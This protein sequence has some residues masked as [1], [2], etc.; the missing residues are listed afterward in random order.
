M[1]LVA[2][3]GTSRKNVGGNLFDAVR[4]QFDKDTGGSSGTSAPPLIDAIRNDIELPASSG[5]GMAPSVTVGDN[6]A[7]GEVAQVNPV[8]VPRITTASYSSPSLSPSAAPAQLLGGG[9]D[10]PSTSPLMSQPDDGGGETTSIDE[11]VLDILKPKYESGLA[12][13]E[14]QNAAFQGRDP[15]TANVFGE[16]YSGDDQELIGNTAV[17]DAYIRDALDNGY[18]SEQDAYDIMHRDKPWLEM[19]SH[20]YSQPMFG[21]ELDMNTESIGDAT[22][23][24]DGSSYD[25]DHMTADKMT[26]AQYMRYA[27]MG[28]G[29]RPIEEIDPLG[30]YS[31]RR[32]Q[33]DHDFMPFMP[34]E[35]SYVNMVTSNVID[36]PSRLGA[37]IANLRTDNPFTPDYSI[38]YGTGDGR[39]TISGKDFDKLSTAYLNQFDWYDRFR[40]EKYLSE[41]DNSVAHVKEHVIPDSTGADTYHYGTLKSVDQNDDGTFNL[42]FS[43]GSNVDISREY[44][45]S[46]YDEST[47]SFAVPEPAR[48]P[49]SKAHGVLPE[50]LSSLNDM[51]QI[52]SMAEE[53]GG[54]P[55]DYADVIYVPDMVMPNGE[56][57][58]LEDVNRI[59]ADK[60]PENDE[61]DS[62]DDDLEY[63]FDR[64][65]I[66]FLTD[67]KP[68]RLTSQEPFGVNE[69]TGRIEADLSDMGNN[70]W[71]WTFGSIPISAPGRI[72]WT[73]SLFNA[74]S[75]LSGADPS[76]YDT[77][78]DSYGL[79]AGNY[80]DEGKPRYGVYDEKGNRNDE[81]SDSNLFWNTAG[82]AA[83]PLTEMLV[84]PIGEELIP[85][86]KFFRK[87]TPYPTFG[88]LLKNT[89]IGAAEEGIEED[90]GNV[91]EDLT[92]YGLPGL[93]A[94]EVKDEQGNVVYDDTNRALRDY[95]TPIG[96]RFANALDVPSLLN[97]FIG[98]AAVTPAMDLLYSPLSN[99][100]FFRQ[101]GPSINRSRAIRNTG[102]TP[103]VET[104]QEREMRE[105]MERGERPDEIREKLSDQYLQMFSTET[106]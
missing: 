13:W 96:D 105:A 22:A 70:M 95:D 26:G 53:Y 62:S 74:A 37:A 69:T 104:D 63:G 90:L 36:T 14:I 40:P 72:P 73:Y 3:S 75:G 52:M 23:M 99:Q 101:L 82:N 91:F 24:D 49:V 21:A 66:P 84:G 64:G 32:E 20:K 48:V 68:R 51:D 86:G 92:Q 103:Y 89:I 67:N 100:T 81:L 98:G 8:S 47:N 15:R 4:N 46:I 41:F 106:D 87:D 57:V 71:D 19:L 35:T 45:D 94:N 7:G 58:S 83:V 50:D 10:V 27:N 76:R 25:Y 77:A 38:S 93:F 9:G 102:I 6:A 28:M 16:E 18:L 30:V 42:K 34:D 65:L 44:F 85:I 11:A 1:A 61:K 78:T 29:G 88:Q 12:D 54:S 2:G 39:K 56:H 55:L 31:K 79:I 59:I 17:N 60:S 5:G 80:D 97:S 33:L 43:D